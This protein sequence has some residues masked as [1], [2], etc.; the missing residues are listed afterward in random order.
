ME[1]VTVRYPV[2]FDD[3]AMRVVALLK[4][5]LHG[6]C[7]QI[8]FNRDDENHRADQTRTPAALF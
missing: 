8:V 5:A 3:M 1:S 4:D 2:A 7:V 6:Q